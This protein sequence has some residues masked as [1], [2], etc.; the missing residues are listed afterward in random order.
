M[1]LLLS[2]DKI[3]AGE[4]GE[5]KITKERK[6]GGGEPLEKYLIHWAFSAYVPQSDTVLILKNPGAAVGD[7][8]TL[9]TFQFPSSSPSPSL[10]LSPTLTSFSSSAHTP[11]S[12]PP[13]DPTNCV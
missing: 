8:E 13:I 12:C 5:K 2:V 9:A 1:G 6:E 11:A 7:G 10:S 3:R 4:K